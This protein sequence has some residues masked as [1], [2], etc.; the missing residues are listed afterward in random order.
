[1]KKDKIIVPK[2]IRFLG[3]WSDFALPSHPC[4][5]NKQITGCGFT[6]FCLSSPQN[7]ILCSPRKILLE[8]KEEQH[9][10]NVYYVKNNLEKQPNFEKDLNKNKEDLTSEGGIIDYTSEEIKRLKSGIKSYITRCIIENRPCKILVTYDSFRLVKDSI[11]EMDSQ[12]INIGMFSV[13]VDEWQAIFVDSTFK[14]STEVDFVY[15]LQGINNLCFVSATPMIDKYL[16]MLDEFK[17]LPYYELDWAADDP[18]RITKPF[19]EVHPTGKSIVSIAADIIDQ[20]RQ[21]KGEVFAFRDNNGDIQEI[22]SKEAV[23]FVNSVKNICDIIRKA[24]LNPSEVNV[25]CSRDPD[26]NKKVKAALGVKGRGVDVLGK[27]PTKGEPHKMF[28]LCTRT[29]YLGADFYST[30]AKSY[31]FSDA[32]IDCLT[33]DI[34]LDLPQILGRQRLESNPWKNRAELYYKT[35]ADSKEETLEELKARINEKEKATNDILLS[36]S[37][38]PE[39]SRHSVARKYQRDAKN[40]NYKYDYVAVNVHAGKDLVPVF[41]NLVKISDLRNYEIQQVDYKDRFSVMNSLNGGGNN[42][43]LTNIDMVIQDILSLP[44]FPERMKYIYDLKLP[45]NIIEIVLSRIPI[46][47]G[48]FYRSVTPEEAKRLSYRKGELEKRYDRSMNNQQVDI[49]QLR[50]MIYREFKVGEK[51]TK[52]YIKDKLGEIYSDCGYI[53][54]PKA[55]DLEEYFELSLCLVPNKTTGKRDSGFEILKKK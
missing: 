50:G 18:L 23:F 16:E 27:V 14:S 7:L 8:N 26:N 19:L 28:T 45:E 2:G 31:I 24:K 37:L 9:H 12:N 11:K 44:G 17:D 53:R 1:M 38:T 49:D 55:N 20:Y 43:I 54:T 36:F 21:G 52:S 29:V 15:Q 41:N 25:L 47:Y 51:Y 33:V 6:E 39:E 46:I 10:G 42:V 35:L 30:N 4:I 22:E 34:T 32:N 13:V 3:E 5:I 40:S 48:N